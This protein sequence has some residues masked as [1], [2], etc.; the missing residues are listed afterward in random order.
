MYFLRST[1]NENKK[2]NTKIFKKYKKK[3]TENKNQEKQGK[4]SRK[5]DFF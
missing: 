4:N 2:Y 5:T 3:I 1:E